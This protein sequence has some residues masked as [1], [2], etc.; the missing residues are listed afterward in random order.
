MARRIP[1]LLALVWSGWVMAAAPLV[2]DDRRDPGLGAANVATHG[3]THGATWRAVTDTV[4][5]GVSR[6]RLEPARVE[7]R[8]CLRLAGEV[9]LENDGGFAQASLDLDRNGPLDARDYAG[10]EIEVYGNGETYNL[11]LR[12]ADTRIVWQSYRASFAA[13][14]AWQTLRL[15]FA[16]FRPHRIDVPLDL[17]ALRRIGL[18]AIGRAMPVDLCIARLSLYP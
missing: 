10:V 9:S 8:P 11:H 5:G 15:P 2:L 13:P 18:V 12:T 14:P 16:A 7:G 17:S 1:G 6:A 4:M 3:A